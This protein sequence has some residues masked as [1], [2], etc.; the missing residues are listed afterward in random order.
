MKA[1]EQIKMYIYTYLHLLYLS[2]N[3]YGSFY[4]V[5]LFC[6]LKANKINESFLLLPLKAV[7]Q[8]VDCP[9]N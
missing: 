2:G 9:S 3:L 6:L 8:H 1:L 4:G 7:W 5:Y